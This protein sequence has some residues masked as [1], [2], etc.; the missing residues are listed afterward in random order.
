MVVNVSY[1]LIVEI[2]IYFSPPMASRVG[3]ITFEK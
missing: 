2:V 1:L 3:D